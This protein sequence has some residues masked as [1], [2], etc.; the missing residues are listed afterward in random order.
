MPLPYWNEMGQRI[1]EGIIMAEIYKVIHQYPEFCLDIE[2]FS[3]RVHTIT[4]LVGENG[5]GKSTLLSVLA[6]E[7][8]PNQEFMTNGWDEQETLYIPSEIGVYNYLKVEEFLEF[9]IKYNHTDYNKKTSAAELLDRLELADKKDVLIEHLSQGMRKKLTLV[10]LFLRS[11]QL[12]L[13]DEPFN[14]ID[15]QYIYQMKQYLRQLCQ[16]T[17]T[18][19]ILSSHIMDTMA[20]LC[21]QIFVIRSGK[22]EKRI[23]NP[24]SVKELE[25]A[26]F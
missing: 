20:D 22:I 26:V 4:G 18:A 11:Y 5:A 14:S 19:V 7:L 8:H 15:F 6:G 2:N 16:S 3:Y 21:D 12:V 9:V 23:K 13:L 10:P 25:E 24:K 1:I 17:D